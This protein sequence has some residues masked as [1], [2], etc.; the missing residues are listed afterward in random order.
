PRLRQACGALAR[1]GVPLALD[2]GD[3]W[4]VNVIVRRRGPVCLDWEDAVLGH[5]FWGAFMLPWSHGFWDRWG[6][7]SAAASRV[8]GAYLAGWA[9]REGVARY[10]TMFERSRA[11]APLHH[12]AI[13][14][15]DVLPHTRTS[16]ATPRTSAPAAS[17]PRWCRSPCG[18]CGRRA[19]PSRPS[20]APCP[21]PSCNG[22]SPP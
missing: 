4:A 7:R 20:R 13:W 22:P 5:P 8:Q 17:P 18:A 11:L 21:G 15:H 3:L 14:G 9:G 19:A 6:H 16:R 10:R 2:H 1:S 12:A